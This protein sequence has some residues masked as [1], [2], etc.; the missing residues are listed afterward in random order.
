MSKN[1]F[2]CKQRDNLTSLHGQHASKHNYP[3]IHVGGSWRWR[4]RWHP[5]RYS[6]IPHTRTH[7]ANSHSYSIKSEQSVEG[8]V[9]LSIVSEFLFYGNQA[10]TTT[11]L[12]LGSFD[13]ESAETIKHHVGSVTT[14]TSQCFKIIIVLAAALGRPEEHVQIATICDTN[15]LCGDIYL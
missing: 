12:R 2:Q 13:E 7:Q 15:P 14:L 8:C 1:M 3:Y 11:G 4:R 6:H 5:H 10:C 9:D